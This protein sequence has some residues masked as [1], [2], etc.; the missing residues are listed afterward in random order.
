RYVAPPAGLHPA[1]RWGTEDGLRDLLADG[2]ESLQAT[3]QMFVW[4]FA[5]PEQYLDLF[6][7]YYGPILKAFAVL[8]EPGQ[9]A[10]AD[11][12]CDAVTRYARPAGSTLLVPA[13][14]LE[15]VAVRRGN[16]SIHV[17]VEVRP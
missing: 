7:S 8:D 13:E 10:R 6:R 16:S 4:R 14:Y 17:G 2:V 12:L 9:R 15:V 1:T 3:R 5:S 11:D